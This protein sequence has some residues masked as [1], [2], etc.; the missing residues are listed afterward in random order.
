MTQP[1]DYSVII[2][3]YN[4]AQQLAR[5]LPAIR[6]AMAQLQQRGEL[7]VV[8]NNS[9]DATAEVA[10]AHGATVVFEPVNQIAKARNAGVSAATSDAF[11]FVDADTTPDAEL[12]RQ[13]VALMLDDRAIGGGGIV[14]MDSPVPWTVRLVLG[15][16]NTVSRWFRLSAGCFF[17]CQREGF[18]ASGGFPESVYASEEIWLGR[19]LRRLGRQQGKPMTIL[20]EP[21]VKTSARKT[22]QTFRVAAMMIL[23]MVFPF[24]VR[25]RSLCGYW[26]KRRD[27]PAESR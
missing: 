14:E 15:F 24:A 10:R 3:A 22:D 16:W 2:P 21:T 9:S 4:E 13:A 8:D 17:F 11:I 6:A 7:I 27:S 19:K 1:P 23:F 26:Y 25:Y 20:R 5:T 18:E 12:L